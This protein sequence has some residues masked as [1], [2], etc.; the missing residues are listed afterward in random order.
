MNMN[1]HCTSFLFL[2]SE[3]DDVEICPN[4]T[5][6]RCREKLIHRYKQGICKVQ[7]KPW[8]RSSVENV[9]SIY[10]VVQMYKKDQ[11]GKTL[12][13]HEK[14]V[15]ENSVDEIFT[16]K[17]NGVLPYRI[18]VIAAAGKGK[19]TAVAKMAY[20]WAYCT[21]DSPFEDLPLLFIL[22]L[23]NV[24]KRSSLGKA[25]IA[26]LL[27]DVKELTPEVM[28]SF[29]D[30]HQ[31]MCWIILDGLDE[32]SVRI[33]SNSKDGKNIVRI[34][35]NVDLPE[36]RVLVTS[37]P[38]LEKDFDR[39]ELP[40]V[41]A[42]MV[43][44][45]FS[46]EYSR[47][48][49][50]KFF[51]NDHR[52]ESLGEYLDKEDI[53][54]ELVSTPLFCLM[55]CYLWKEGLLEGT[56]TQTSLFDQVNNFLWHHW[57]RKTGKDQPGL[58]NKIV[59]SLG[60][61]ALYGLLDDSKKLIF[62]EEDFKADS[63]ALNQGCR[64]GI[65]SS[66]TIYHRPV[67]PSEKHTK[68]VIEFYHRLAQEHSAGK[69]LAQESSKLR[70]RHHFAKYDNVIKDIR[71]RI[72]DYENLLRFTAGTTDEVCV[73]VIESILKNKTLSQGNKYRILL[74]CSSESNTSHLNASWSL[75][76]L[77]SNDS[78]CIMYPTIYTVIGFRNLP[79]DV[80]AKVIVD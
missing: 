39:E 57:K 16:T 53:I 67:D 56:K 6:K 36:C 64:M 75:K 73:R 47:E 52:S 14:V 44:E 79:K 33:T 9:K 26:N 22:K 66:T 45:G 70:L 78:V 74:D 65:I 28:N 7:I 30:S 3:Y 19:T 37:R 62:T 20:D 54:N 11:G 60:K 72:G 8:D 58:L 71:E 68:N 27:P 15:L 40:F 29:I 69:Y 49:I 55:V 25:I 31:K 42:K 63:K 80:V 51:H 61:V 21:E 41:Y 35:N 4:L 17:V 48:Y 38:H 23:R 32:Y 1:V 50:G 59:C 13:E 43:I 76:K 46:Q 2:L 5:V 10:T 77:I 34:L 18:L 12:G 24:D